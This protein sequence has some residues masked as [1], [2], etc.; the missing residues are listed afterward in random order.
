LIN[1]AVVKKSNI[2]PEMKDVAVLNYI[3]LALKAHF[4]RF[5]GA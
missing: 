2:K 4:P 5:F 3:I 1:K